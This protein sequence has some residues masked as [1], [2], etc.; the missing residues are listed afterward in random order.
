MIKEVR[1]NKK[2]VRDNRKEARDIKEVKIIRKVID[3]KKDMTDNLM[4]KNL[5]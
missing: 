4:V 5:E 1:D 2:E 3:Y